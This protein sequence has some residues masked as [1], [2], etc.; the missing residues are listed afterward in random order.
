[1]EVYI[2]DTPEG[3]STLTIAA[4]NT[5]TSTLTYPPLSKDDATADGSR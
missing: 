5:F 3:G 4:D 1:M 2:P